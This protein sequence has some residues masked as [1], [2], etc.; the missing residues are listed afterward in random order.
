LRAIFARSYETLGWKSS[1]AIVL[2]YDFN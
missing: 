2:A 1:N